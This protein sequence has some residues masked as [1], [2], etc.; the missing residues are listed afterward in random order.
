MQT[1]FADQLQSVT[2]PVRL[3]HPHHGER[4]VSASAEACSAGRAGHSF[5]TAQET[6]AEHLQ[7]LVPPSCRRWHNRACTAPS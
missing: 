4:P 1:T 5:A 6:C 2:R 7:R 3:V